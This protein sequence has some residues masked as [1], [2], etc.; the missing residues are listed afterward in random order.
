MA[1]PPPH[2]PLP[3]PLAY[4]PGSYALDA[5]ARALISYAVAGAATARV[6]AAARPAR[7]GSA[8]R[9][10]ACLAAAALLLAAPRFVV[11]AAREAA[12][13]TPVVGVFSLAAFKAL[14]FA[15]GR[16]PLQ[17]AHLPTY[18]KF[19]AA[20]AMPVIPLDAFKLTSSSSG[21]GNG[22]G[23]GNS[24]GSS[25]SSG[26]A[27]A[28]AAS[29]GAFLLS[30]LVKAACAAAAALLCYLPLHAYATHW[31][32]AL[33]LSLSVGAL[34]DLYAAVAVAFAGLAVAP[35]FDAPWMSSSF[36]DYWA[37]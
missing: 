35:S 4:V 14:A 24:K 33:T 28:Q 22:N 37:R 23:N 5:A 20:M 25:N 11:D 30:Y 31:L 7:P 16:G 26:A 32:Y 29:A 12:M 6:Y 27:T 34:W 10:A 9:A 1:H 18:A 17:L 19:A 36:A 8:Q 2:P 21:G 3:P 15:V 13:V